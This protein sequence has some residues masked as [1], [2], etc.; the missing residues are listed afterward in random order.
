MESRNQVIF[1]IV[2][3][4]LCSFGFNLFR[5]DGGIELVSVP[6]SI[7]DKV[8]V[9]DLESKEPSIRVIGLE[10]AKKLHDQGHLF[11]DAR[12]REYLSDGIIPNA[13]SNNN[14]DSLAKQ[15]SGVISLNTAFIVY[16][17]DDD[18]GSSEEL[19]YELQAWGFN[20][21]L[22]FTGGWKKWTEAEL[23]IGIYE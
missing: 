18:C 22:V 1:I 11:V 5:T 15:I 6:L 17:S 21:I 10:I 19:A 13:I 20:N 8:E 16:C 23:E 3:S 2:V 9:V 14:F 7:I 4:F 12:A